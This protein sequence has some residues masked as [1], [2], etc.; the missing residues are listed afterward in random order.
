MKLKLSKGTP[1]GGNKDVASKFLHDLNNN[2][3]EF[4]FS[5]V[6]NLMNAVVP[7]SPSKHLLVAVKY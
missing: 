4:P 6:K 1:Y 3:S 5:A 7:P 2:I